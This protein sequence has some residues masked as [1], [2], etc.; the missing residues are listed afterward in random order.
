M[1]IVPVRVNNLHQVIEDFELFQKF[2]AL[3]EVKE[4][5]N[6]TSFV[7]VNN[8]SQERYSLSMV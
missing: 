5:C 8:P 6:N 2:N 4:I 1:I 7:V 3:Y